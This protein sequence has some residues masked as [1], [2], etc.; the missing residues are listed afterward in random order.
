MRRI[1]ALVLTVVAIAVLAGLLMAD[2]QAAAHPSYTYRPGCHCGE[3]ATTTTQAPTTT[4]AAAPTTTT[5][6]ATTTTTQGATTTTTGATTTTTTRAPAGF[7]DVPATHAY[8][9]AIMGVAAHSIMTGYTIPG[10]REFR[11]NN[12]LMRAEFAQIACKALRID[13]MTDHPQ[14]FTDLGPVVAGNPYPH[15]YV[16][17]AAAAGITKGTAPGLF[18]PWLSITRAQVVT[19]LVRAAN[20]LQPGLVATPP[21]SFEG[22]LGGFSDVH[23]V[24]MRQAEFNGLLTGIVGFGPAWDPW[25]PASRGEAAQ[26][27]WGLLQE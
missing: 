27:V 3:P 23:A 13:P 25:A 5:T 7:A 1:V 19:M 2:R 22:S 9:A 14:P 10:G 20:S 11:P 16:A 12:D 15:R 4:T 24:A 21:A 8:R 18:S 26:M 6:A 17:A